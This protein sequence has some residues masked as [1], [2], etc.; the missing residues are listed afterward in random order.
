M[1]ETADGV[2]VNKGK[3]GGPAAKA[4]HV[5]LAQ[6]RDLDR[7]GDHLHER[8]RAL[9]DAHGMTGQAAVV[10]HAFRWETDFAFRWSEGWSRTSRTRR[11]SAT[12][13]A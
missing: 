4:A 9:I 11:T 12:S 2:T 6:R 7:L 10:D 1:K 3:T 13:S 5:E 8:Y